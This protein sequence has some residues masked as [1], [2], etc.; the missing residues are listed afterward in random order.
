M[1]TLFERGK[2]IVR[3]EAEKP[4]T[5]YRRLQEAIKDGEATFPL[6]DRELCLAAIEGVRAGAYS[7]ATVALEELSLR[8]A[9]DVPAENLGRAA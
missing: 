5:A 6:S 4:S 1:E 8:L 7:T 2:R 9:N 3:A